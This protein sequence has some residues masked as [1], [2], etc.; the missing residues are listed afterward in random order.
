MP[1]CIRTLTRACN[2]ASCKVK[3]KGGGEKAA[4]RKRK[5]GKDEWTSDGEDSD[6]DYGELE[7][8]ASS[9]CG[10]RPEILTPGDP[11]SWIKDPKGKP[12]C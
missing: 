2:L 9:S 5:R 1:Y 8:D 4:Q 11:Q 10:N 7:S 3:A 6:A 12:C